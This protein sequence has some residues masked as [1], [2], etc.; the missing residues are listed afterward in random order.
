MRTLL[1]ILVLFQAVSLAEQVP[2]DHRKILGGKKSNRASS[3]SLYYSPTVARAVLSPPIGFFPLLTALSVL[4]IQ[5][6][7]RA[8]IPFCSAVIVTILLPPEMLGGSLYTRNTITQG[9]A[10]R[11]EILPYSKYS[12]RFRYPRSRF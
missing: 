8:Y 1:Y 9:T 2:R 7:I 4:T 6:P 5:F 12:A 11:R 10:L 3:L